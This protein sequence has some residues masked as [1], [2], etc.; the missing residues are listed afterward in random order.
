[1][2][3]TLS[4]FI[5]RTICLR[6]DFSPESS[7][8]CSGF[9]F[10]YRG[11]QYVITAAH[12]LHHD[13]EIRREILNNVKIVKTFNITESML[14]NKANR[15]VTVDK[16]IDMLILEMEKLIFPVSHLPIFHRMKNPFR[17]DY[18]AKNKI[19]CAG[20]PGDLIPSILNAN[21][22]ILRRHLGGIN[23]Y[24]FSGRNFIL[25]G[26]SCH[27][28]SGGPAVIKKDGVWRILGILTGGFMRRE[29]VMVDPTEAPTK[30]ITPFTPKN[31]CPTNLF[32]RST[33][34]FTLGFL[35]EDAV[36]SL[37]DVLDPI[38]ILHKIP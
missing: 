8:Y 5:S 16:N 9:V 13:G 10:D 38:E 24:H 17:I 18:N 37:D 29:T 19:V 21:P 36:S 34:G 25:D 31:E 15:I 20:Y 35:I 33:L 32:A 7:Y 27:G 1:M 4:D 2:L 12:F 28:F 6:V 26:D 23:S 30:I 14:D 11:R 22:I 3:T